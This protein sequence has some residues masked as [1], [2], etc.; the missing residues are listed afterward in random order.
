MWITL[1]LVVL[2]GS[3]ILTLVE[4]NYFLK[5]IHRREPSEERP[6]E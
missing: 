5:I 3:A 6:N 4:R 2:K 1:L